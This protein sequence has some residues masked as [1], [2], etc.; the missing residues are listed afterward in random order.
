[1]KYILPSLLAV[2]IVFNQCYSQADPEFPKGFIM[3]LKLHNGMITNFKSDPDLYVG[4]IQIVPQMAIVEHLLRGGIIVDGFYTDKK[5]Q[6]AFGPTISLKVK[7]FNAGVFGSAAN[8]NLSFDHLWGT[9]KQKLVGGGINADLGNI[10]VIALTAH[11]DY[12]FCNWW[13]Q[14]S[15]GIR[16]SKKKKIVEPFN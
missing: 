15:I 7:T 4:G 1:M 10:I 12:E 5:L 2:I 13:F 3:H 11:Y 9:E 6:A 16:I 8:L 14:N